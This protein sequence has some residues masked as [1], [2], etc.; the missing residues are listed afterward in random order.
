LAGL[1]VGGV[2][3]VEQRVVR[4]SWD[5]FEQMA[6]P[7]P[8]AGGGRSA[9]GQAY[10]IELASFNGPD[11]LRQAYDFSH[12][13]RVDAGVPDV[14]FVNR[15]DRAVVY[16]GRF[17]RPNHPDAKAALK[18]VRTAK[19]DGQ[20]P[21][22]EAQL[23][24]ID[25]SRGVTG[26]FDLAQFSGYRT[27][28]LAVFDPDYPNFREAAEQYADEL[29]DEHDL[30]LYFYHGANQSIVTAGLFTLADFV[31]VNGVDTYGPAIRSLQK[32]FPFALRNGRTIPNPEVQNEEK[33]EPTIVV[34]V[35]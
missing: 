17:S 29:R 8:N 10:G 18:A 16:S 6:D 34:N 19:L 12:A 24:P 20:R 4:S 9:P 3:C 25:R 13:A 27:L 23:S 15:G 22:R 30:P 14:W 26:E 31:P 11:R 21:F 33:L 35:P 5:N 2:G 32:T 7:P 1:L 28:L